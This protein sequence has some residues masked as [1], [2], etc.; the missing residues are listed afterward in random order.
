MRES[1]VLA[2]CLLTV[3]DMQVKCSDVL[4]VLTS[5]IDVIPAPRQASIHFAEHLVVLP[6]WSNLN[7]QLALK[8]SRKQ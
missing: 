4:K 3:T 6:F 1:C 7:E 2:F 5:S 8:H